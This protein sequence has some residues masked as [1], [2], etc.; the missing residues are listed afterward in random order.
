M[1]DHSRDEGCSDTSSARVRPD[2][3]A[4][5]RS[6]VPKLG[7]VRDVEAGY[8]NEFIVATPSAEDSLVLQGGREPREWLTIFSL[9]G[10]TEGFG[11]AGKAVETEHSER[12]RVARLKSSDRARESQIQ[13]FT[14]ILSLTDRDPWSAPVRSSAA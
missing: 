4:S 8:T 5:E 1:V 11:V 9:P 7:C 14:L 2:E 3:D 10:C 13:I 6:L 12:C